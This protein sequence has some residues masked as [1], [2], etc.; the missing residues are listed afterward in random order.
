MAVCYA[1]LKQINNLLD[2]DI[3][4]SDL[5]QLE[6]HLANCSN[7]RDYLERAQAI[8]ASFSSLPRY[9]TSGSFDIV[10]REKLRNEIIYLGY[11][12]YQDL[13]KIYSLATIFVY[14]SFYEGFGLPPIEAMACGCPVIT[15][16]VTSLPEVCADAA[17]YIDPE[18]IDSISQAVA[19]VAEDENLR[20]KMTEKG[21]ENARRFDWKKSAKAHLDIF[22]EV[23]EK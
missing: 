21:L 13:P 7:C 2:D 22:T 15:S 18:D 19:E 14:P 20:K 12:P 6:A 23:A 3:E 5:K 1:F 10:L 11:V 8:Q 4:P 17:R 9:K 16:N